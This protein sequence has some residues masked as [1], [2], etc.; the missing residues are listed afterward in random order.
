MSGYSSNSDGNCQLF[1]GAA[2]NRCRQLHFSFCEQVCEQLRPARRWSTF[3][4][5][6]FSG[7]RWPPTQFRR[8]R[9]KCNSSDGRTPKTPKDP[10]Q[11]KK[12]DHLAAEAVPLRQQLWIRTNP[13]EMSLVSWR[14]E[15]T[16]N[17]NS[18]NVS[19]VIFL[20][21]NKRFPRNSHS[22]THCNFTGGCQR[23][24]KDL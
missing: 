7:C 4:R 18:A 9:P 13:T 15:E 12:R 8:K 24:K 22:P 19:R 11:P 20:Y 6:R 23:K 2:A 1:E 10:P 5:D 3:R 21:S 16:E 17:N 14:Q